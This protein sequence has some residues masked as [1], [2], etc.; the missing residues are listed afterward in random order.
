MAVATHIKSIPKLINGGE[1]IC[2][3]SVALR[4]FL[5]QMEVISDYSQN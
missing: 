4:C 5:F 3:L 2:T 1:V